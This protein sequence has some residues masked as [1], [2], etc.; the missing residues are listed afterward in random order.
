MGKIQLVFVDLICC[1]TYTEGI[2]GKGRGWA[3]VK[4]E[5]P[6]TKFQRK[7]GDQ[8][9]S[10][11]PSQAILTSPIDCWTSQERVPITSKPPHVLKHLV[12]ASRFA[13]FL[14]TRLSWFMRYE[15][16]L[17][18]YFCLLSCLQCIG[19]LWLKF[20]YRYGHLPFLGFQAY[21]WGFLVQAKLGMDMDTMMIRA[22]SPVDSWPPMKFISCLLHF[23]SWQGFS[24]GVPSVGKRMVT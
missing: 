22:S 8:I 16:I 24:Y 19:M 17:I 13:L 23:W 20:E 7:S 12:R 4:E 2:Q 5:E 9:P 1:I 11:R 14:E 21:F 6:T 3:V 15:H 10:Y 18:M